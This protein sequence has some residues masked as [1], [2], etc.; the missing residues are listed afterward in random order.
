MGGLEGQVMGGLE[1]QVMD[2]PIARYHRRGNNIFFAAKAIRQV[3]IE[4]ITKEGYSPYPYP[5]IL[6][7]L[8]SV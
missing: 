6:A 4:E 5:I 3:N 1:G 8:T 2:V 7:C